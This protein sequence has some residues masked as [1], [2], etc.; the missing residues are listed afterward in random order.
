MDWE[1][2]LHLLFCFA[3]DLTTL[4]NA[5]YVH[6]NLTPHNVLVFNNGSCAIGSFSKC[7]RAL[8]LPLPQTEELFGYLPYAAPEFLRHKPYTKASDIYA[9][10]MTMYTIATGLIP[11][12]TYDRQ[13]EILAISIC[14]GDRPTIPYR[15]P[16][17]YQKLMEKCWN[18]EEN[19]RPKF[20]G[21][22]TLKV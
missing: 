6:R 20:H 13:R 7:R 11:F 9:F 10:G 14:Q 3:E 19:L 18:N 16:G 1:I 17:S 21:V 4:H 5:G 2:K 22:M 15:L 8:P 12:E